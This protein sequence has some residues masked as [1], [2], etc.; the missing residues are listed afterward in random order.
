M[1][2]PIDQPDIDG[3]LRRIREEI[4]RIDRQ[5]QRVP[6]VDAHI[7]PANLR[8]LEEIGE[9]RPIRVNLRN[10]RTAESIYSQ[11]ALACIRLSTRHFPNLSVQQRQE[12]YD[13]MAEAYLTLREVIRR[14]PIYNSEEEEEEI[15]N[16]HGQ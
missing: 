12:A 3:Q 15:E 16:I 9:Y 10:T 11:A 14:I 6:A 1:P 13:K 2:V 8:Q 7:V 5:A 4:G